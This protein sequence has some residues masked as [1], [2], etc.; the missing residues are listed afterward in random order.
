MS[1]SLYQ[2]LK[3][4]KY[5]QYVEIYKYML[6]SVYWTQRPVVMSLWTRRR[7]CWV[8][9]KSCFVFFPP[10]LTEAW[11]CNLRTDRGSV[12]RL[13][14]CSWRVCTH[15]CRRHPE[16]SACVGLTLTLTHGLCGRQTSVEFFQNPFFL[17]SSSSSSSALTAT[18]FPG[19]LHV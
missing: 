8:I 10:V 17:L 15:R 19:L 18:C 1:C 7:N 16:T 14:H 11:C 12:T 2:I 5:V 13:C 6:L 3:Y 9:L 4:V